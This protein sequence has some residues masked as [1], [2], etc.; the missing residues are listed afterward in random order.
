[1]ISKIKPLINRCAEKIAR[2]FAHIFHPNTL[3]L[4]GF[5]LAIIPI[6]LLSQKKYLWGALSFI[7]LCADVLDG[8]VARVTQKE[9]LF[10]GYL[11]AVLDRIVDG[12]IIIAL[13]WSGATQ[14]FIGLLC[15]LNF[16]LVSYTKA[17]G[18]GVLGLK[19]M[20]ANILAIGFAERG[21]R[22]VLIFIGLL[23][24]S[25]SQ[26]RIIGLNILEMTLLILVIL[27]VATSLQRIINVMKELKKSMQ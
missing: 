15:V 9:S 7:L 22:L 17:K 3:T 2:P 18:E 21:V 19:K 6:I 8:A 16:S 25:F 12:L 11:D 5:L 23:F 13:V 24:F 1:M 27:S 4:I 20:G 10:G 26:K 14:P